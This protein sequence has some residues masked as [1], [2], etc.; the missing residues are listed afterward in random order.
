[1]SE[2]V[3]S[4]DQILIVSINK[5]K[6]VS[7]KFKLHTVLKGETMYSISKKYDVAVSDILKWNNKKDNSL[8]VGDK[9]NI[10]K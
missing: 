7:E 10:L 9:L 2:P 6:D 3:I 1:M 4:I 5:S 8:S